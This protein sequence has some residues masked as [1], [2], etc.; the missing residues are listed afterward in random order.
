MNQTWHFDFLGIHWMTGLVAC[1]SLLL[2]GGTRPA[3]AQEA[4]SLETLTIE[5]G[6]FQASGQRLNVEFGTL[7]VP[8]NRSNPA[9]R[10]LELRFVRLKSTSPNPGPPIV[11]LAG[12]PGGS[13]IGT[14]RGSR[15]RLFLAMRQIADVIAFDQRGTG[16]AAGSLRC[17]NKEDIPLDRPGG[18]GLYRSRVQKFASS[19]VELMRKRGVDL[20]GYTTAESADDLE[21]LREAL[22]ADKLTL[23]GISYGSHL[24]LATARRHPG[25][26]DRMM[27]A[28]IEG[29]NH[30]FK[31]PSNIE[32]NLRKLA[33]LVAVDSTY[34]G[35]PDLVEA[36]QAILDR[37]EREP[38][39]VEALPKRRVVIGKW[40][41][42]KRVADV[43][44]S[45]TA[46][47]RL[48][49]ALLAMSQGD[50]GDLAR[51]AYAFRKPRALS[52]MTLAMDCASYASPERLER[53]ERE[54]RSALLGATIDYPFP[55]I[56]QV[57]G[58]P[59]LDEG[60]RAPL[61][62]DIPTL[63]ISGTLDGRTPVE[64]AEEVAAG[65]PNGRHLVIQGAAHSDPLFLSSPT[66]LETMLAFARGE[67]INDSV[68]DGPAWTFARPFA[69]SL[70]DDVLTEL[71]EGN[72]ATTVDWY[73]E[74]RRAL[75]VDSIYDFDERVLNRLGYD[76]LGADEAEL[77]LAVF[78]LNTEAHPGAFN[79]W[80]SL[81]EA[82]LV[83][84]DTLRAIR[85]Y[86]KSLALN[87]QN[88]NARAVLSQIQEKATARE[89]RPR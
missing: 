59:R 9:S 22:G 77:A 49:A 54:G 39:R 80:D 37:L 31:L 78:R 53:I 11:Y 47:E 83:L 12:G 75:G 17:E 60:F 62:S 67:E 65:F 43:M 18:P 69:R 82:Y 55:D 40:D 19:C 14:A 79:T 64:N 87:P 26:I 84:G 5:P 88:G 42:Q 7:R 34:G 24:A 29:P 27:L 1:G 20:S 51:W 28:G 2:A 8:E 74:Q 48:P 68:I 32:A 72:Y 16:Q 33:A 89:R 52:A 25:S 61:E 45:Q 4:D 50:Y 30:T 10:T 41:L 3:A 66:I 81:G 46:M 71:K 6:T 23:W 36:L 86:R 44:G 58:L 73:H 57:P 38:M 85:N 70:A 15:A 13:G 76:L 63:F 35:Q 21:D 56:C